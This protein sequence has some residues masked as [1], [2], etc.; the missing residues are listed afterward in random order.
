MGISGMG[1]DDGVDTG[2][3]PTCTGS[4]DPKSQLARPTGRCLLSV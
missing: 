2:W 4:F 3:H 1:G